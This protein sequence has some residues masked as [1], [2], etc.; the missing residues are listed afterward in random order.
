MNIIMLLW[1]S[2]GRGNRVGPITLASDS[3]LWRFMSFPFLVE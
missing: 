2:L 1:W 3:H